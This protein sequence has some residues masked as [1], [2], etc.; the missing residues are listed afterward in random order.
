M[1]R[2]G[3]K[4]VT[5]EQVRAWEKKPRKPL[6]STSVRRR[7][8][9]LRRAEV[10]LAARVRDGGCVARALVPEIGCHG[11]LDGH[12]VIPRSGWPGGHL[13]V[14][15]VAT[16]CRAHHRWI[17]RN[18]IEAHALGLHGYSWERP[19]GMVGP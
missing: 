10:V 18:L 6:P 1:K 7:A 17:D 2:S 4:R 3:L 9:R 14:E 5:V 11:P 12:E 13:V 16:V 15:N 19:A 8:E